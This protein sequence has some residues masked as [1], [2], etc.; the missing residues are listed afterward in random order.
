MSDTTRRS[1]MATMNT[2]S[3]P[4]S[5]SVARRGSNVA[6]AELPAASSTENNVTVR[7]FPTTASTSSRVTCF[8]SFAARRIL[9]ISLARIDQRGADR[10]DEQIERVGIDLVFLAPEARQH[11]LERFRFIQRRACNRDA[12]ARRHLGKLLVS[13]R[14]EL[15]L[16]P[17]R[18]R[19]PAV[20]QGPA[21]SITYSRSDVESA[22]KS[23]STT[24]RFFAK[25]GN[26][27]TRSSNDC[28]AKSSP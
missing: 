8:V 21:R 3:S 14:F 4:D 12:T 11:T 1:N 26:A 6:G 28:A 16:P 24:R 20:G 7:Y 27:C 19:A 17:T 18:S 25:S 13:D 9:S 23:R 10:F 2:G 22:S 5:M 15:F